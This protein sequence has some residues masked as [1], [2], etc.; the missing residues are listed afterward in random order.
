MVRR[1]GLVLGDQLFE[2]NPVFDYLQ[3]PAYGHDVKSAGRRRA[4]AARAEW[5]KDNVES[6]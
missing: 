3:R 4:I 6:L 2:G 5:L 1:L